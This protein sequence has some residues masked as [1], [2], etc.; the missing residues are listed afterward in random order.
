MK[1]E[2]QGT[3]FFDAPDGPWASA[4]FPLPCV[5]RSGRWLCAFRG[6][7]R[8]VPCT[9]Q[10]TLLTWSDDCG[11]T[12]RTPFRPFTAPTI[13]G[14]PG[15]FRFAG[16]TRLHEGRLLAAINW[17]DQ[18]QPELP[19]FNETTEG[20]L[21]T[22]V[23]LS[24]S[25]DDGATWSIP[26]CAD[27]APFDV[28]T[29]L[30]GSVVRFPDDEL[31][32][33]IEL[34]KHYEDTT[35]WHHASVA[36]FSTDGG[37]TWPRHSV[38]TR[39][40]SNR[41]FYWDQRLSLLP[42]GRLMD[43][44]WTYDREAADYLNIHSCYSE[45][46]GHSWSPLRDTGV[47]GQPGPVFTLEDGE[48]VMPVV[49]RSG[50]PKVTVRRSEDN[51]V[52]WPAADTVVVYDAAEGSQTEKKATMQDAWAEMYAFSVGLPSVAPLPGGGGL[53][54]YYAGSETDSTGIHWAKVE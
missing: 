50:A 49:D 43:V 5:S 24:T 46:R 12:W 6:A 39:D 1:I 8:K 30:T 47:P 16:L 7:P 25:D 14:R 11:A 52:S 15:S 42:D 9:G 3:V 32:C 41:V 35:P 22:R 21:D 53:L 34:N 54:V 48:L 29:P 13:D 45:D 44:F 38:I 19:Y 17:V 28:P 27:L 26:E 4:T 2:A 18:S 31:A 37:K 51:G 23:F 33:Q 40:P 10:D 20:L 36:L